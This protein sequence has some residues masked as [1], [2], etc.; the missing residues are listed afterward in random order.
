MALRSFE[1]SVT[2]HPT[3]ELHVQEDAKVQQYR[4]E[5]AR[6]CKAETVATLCAEKKEQDLLLNQIYDAV[7]GCSTKDILSPTHSLNLGLYTVQPSR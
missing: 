2:T 1:T 3:T 4:C 6:P 5:N 7:H